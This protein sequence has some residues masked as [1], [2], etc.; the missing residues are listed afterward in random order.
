MASLCLEG[1][2]SQQVAL[3][4]EHYCNERT[5]SEQRGLHTEQGEPG[6]RF[7][8]SGSKDRSLYWYREI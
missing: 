2:V 6:L 8:R 1:E 4:P 7:P 5:K 3:G